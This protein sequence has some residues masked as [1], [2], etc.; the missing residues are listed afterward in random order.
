M[1]THPHDTWISPQSQATDA[2]TNQTQ[3]SI[4]ARAL[5]IAHTFAHCHTHNLG[6]QTHAH[7]WHSE[8]WTNTQAHTSHRIKTFIM[9]RP[10]T[11]C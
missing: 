8:Y 3:Y 5:N 7:T 2:N 4:R 11:H 9:T 6:T 1:H 10:H